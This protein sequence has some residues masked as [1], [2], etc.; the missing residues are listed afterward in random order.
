MST[1]ETF[2]TGAYFE[3]PKS[4]SFHGE[5]DAIT[6]TFPLYNNVSYESL[7]R[8]FELCTMLTYQQLANKT[9]RVLLDPPVMYEVEI[10]GKF[11]SPYAYIANLSIQG[12]GAQTHRKIKTLSKFVDGGDQP[13][14]SNSASKTGDGS[15]DDSSPKNNQ[16]G[17]PCKLTEDKT[18]DESLVV[19]AIIP[20][21]WEVTITLQ[22]LVPSTKNLYYHALAGANS[23]YD[24]KVIE[25][26][27]D[28]A[29]ERTKQQISDEANAAYES[30]EPL[31]PGP[32]YT[33]KFSKTHTPSWQ[34]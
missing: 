29:T 26:V 23:I 21:V 16:P 2:R 9:S 22:S 24:V 10:P 18:D 30:G 3:R 13:A 14:E 34:K 31:P 1:A 17:R 27:L 11:Y 6:F 25:P 5:G 32:S 7:V 15:T 28:A 4:Y 33:P 20:D 19:D 8:N 12:L